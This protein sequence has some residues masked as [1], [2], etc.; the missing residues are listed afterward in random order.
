VSVGEESLYVSSGADNV[1]I[2]VSA[3]RSNGTAKDN[4]A[5]GRDAL[6]AATADGNIAVG[7]KA[8]ANLTSGGFNIDIGHPGVAG[9]AQTTRIGADPAS[10]NAQQRA[11]ITGIYGVSITGG[12]TVLINS[13]GQLGTIVSSGRF[14]KDVADMGDSSSHLLD[15]RPVTFHY[16]ADPTQARQY[17]LIAEEVAKVYPDLVVR[18]DKGEIDSV[19]YHELAPMLL[20]ELQKQHREIE[21]LRKERERDVAMLDEMRAMLK[22]QAA[23]LTRLQATPAESVRVAAR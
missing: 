3:L 10:R 2:G 17:G 13:S 22:E 6:T 11:F 21:A 8:G 19:Q 23:V 9:E 16:K 12:S 1:A 7:Y 4:V 18:N 15:L 5:V 20:N 14:K